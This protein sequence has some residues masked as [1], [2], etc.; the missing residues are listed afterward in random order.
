MYAEGRLGRWAIS[1][2]IGL[3]TLAV[4]GS[5][6]AG[7]V[8]SKYDVDLYGYVKLDAVYDSQKTAA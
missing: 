2:L 4:C 8:G 6:V 7:N 5:A 3:T 1:V